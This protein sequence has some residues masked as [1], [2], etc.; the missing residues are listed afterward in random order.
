MARDGSAGA[1]Q[2]LRPST[3]QNVTVTTASAASSAMV[4]NVVRLYCNVD[5]YVSFGAAAT[6]SKMLLPAGI[7]E[8]FRCEP[9]ET[10]NGITASGTGTLNVTEFV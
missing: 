2:A 6:T 5:V 10:V 3:S 4:G 9:G 7:A 1:I 8:Y